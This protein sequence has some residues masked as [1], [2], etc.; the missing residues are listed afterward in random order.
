MLYL[1]V[2][3]LFNRVML[4]YLLGINKGSDYYLAGKSLFGLSFRYKNKDKNSFRF[5]IGSY[6]KTL[7][8]K[9][10]VNENYYKIFG[11]GGTFLYEV[12]GTPA[13][14]KLWMDHVVYFDKKHPD[15]AIW[16]GQLQVCFSITDK[17]WLLL[18]ETLFFLQL[19]PVS[20]FSSLKGSLGLIFIQYAELVNLFKMIKKFNIKELYYCS[21]YETDA[22]I[23][24]IALR[25]SGVKINKI[26]SLTPLKYWNMIILGADRLIVS[27]VNQLEE[28]EKFKDTIRVGKVEVWGPYNIT[29]VADHY[30]K[31]RTSTTEK[32]IG[33]Y[34]TASY[35]RAMAGHIEQ[36][37]MLKN[38]DTVKGYLAD[39]LRQH[40]E[41]K[42]LVLLHPKEK[43]TELTEAVRKHYEGFF[44][45]L[46]YLISDWPNPSIF[47]FEKIN[48]GIAMYSS[49]I[50]ERLYFG[51]KSVMMPLDDTELAGSGTGIARICAVDKAD[52]FSKIDAFLDVSQ[53][54]YFRITGLKKS[55]FMVENTVS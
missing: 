41:V 34:S 50:Y 38:E 2:W 42:L 25:K 43:A 39:Y 48:L 30:R 52:M 49:V 29:M 55:P 54:E 17:L 21:I 1:R 8:L 46:N 7:L 14:E 12:V 51:F 4:Q 22:N 32:I 15:G 40:K 11:N 36:K 20:L 44:G 3:L 47:Y 35:V 19:L 10:P 26:A 13:N 31:N 18:F 16:K 37:N 6:V 24:G 45:G 53:E 23:A 28:I 33:F 5:F 9:K 27:D